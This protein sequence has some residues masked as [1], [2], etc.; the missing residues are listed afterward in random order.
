MRGKSDP[1]L[2]RLH[3]TNTLGL[4]HM[5]QLYTHYDNL[6]VARNAPP[7]VIRAAYKTLSQ[8]Y[9]PDRNLGNSDA[10]RIMT[11]INTSYEVLSDPDK[12]REH[13]Q[14]VAIQELAA[15]K[16][17]NGSGQPMSTPR[18]APTLA[19]KPNFS[20]GTAFS[21][22]VRNWLLYGIA[23]LMVWVWAT[24]TPTT[25]PMGPKPYQA[26]PLPVQPEHVRPT[27][28]PN[29]QP[30]PVSAGYVKKYQRL[31]TA[32]LSAVTVD[33][34]ENNSDVFVKLVSLDGTQ[35]YP[36][37]Q[38]YIPAFGS[39][40]VNKV[41]AGGYDIRYR[42][43]STNSLSRSEA[44]NLEEVSTYTGTQFSNFTMTLYKVQDGNM[45]TYSLSETEF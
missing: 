44:F 17:A 26:T 12:R 45:H 42:D 19:A 9:H 27:T 37:R 24:D 32:G 7:E 40:T 30:W 13:D 33:N 16:T 3:P 25:P 23:G 39:F 8:K 11:I 36:V 21:H 18:S 22:V 34:S 29:G 38:F 31:H 20:L 6:K 28:A 35:A 1:D 2:D 14:W 5:A 4:M 15:E 41:T 43:L 10:A